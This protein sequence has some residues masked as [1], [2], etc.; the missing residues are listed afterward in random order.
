MAERVVEAC[1]SANSAVVVQR[2][3]SS[4]RCS[5]MWSSTNKRSHCTVCPNFSAILDEVMD[6]CPGLCHILQIE[7]VSTIG[8]M[9]LMMSA[10]TPGAR[11]SDSMRAG[12][13]CHHRKCKRRRARWASLSD[14]NALNEAPRSKLLHS[15]IMSICAGPC[16]SGGCGIGTTGGGSPSS[17][18]SHL[19]VIC[20][21]KGLAGKPAAAL[22]PL[23]LELEASGII[24]SGCTCC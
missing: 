5:I 11:R 24:F 7:H 21:S 19:S 23:E 9:R 6:R 10:E 2:R 16:S 12:V 17:S 1:L 18:A 3:A 13:A 14:L 20:H 22:R 8:L 4:I 15:G